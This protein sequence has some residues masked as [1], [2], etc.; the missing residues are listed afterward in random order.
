MGMRD[1]TFSALFLFLLWLLLLF[2]QPSWP[3]L[4]LGQYE[5]E[6][7]VGTWNILGVTNATSIGLGD[8]RFAFATDCSASL[9]NPALI[10]NL[11]KPTF[12]LHSSFHS[13]S[14]FK[15]SIVNTG[16]VTTDKN[17]TLKTYSIDHAAVFVRL[18]GWAF[19]L[20]QALTEIYDRPSVEQN[21]YYK[22]SLYYTLNFD[23]EGNLKT[24]HFSAARKITKR[25]SLGLGINYV[26]G[27]LK[28]NLEERWLNTNITI[29]DNK[30]HDFK[31][32]YFNGGVWARL[33]EKLAVAAIFRTPYTKKAESQSLYRYQSPQGE[34][35]IKIEASSQNK[36]KQPLVLGLGISYR[37]SPKIRI[38]S[39]LSFF[40]W[41]K[42]KVNYYE[43]ELERNFKNVV[44]VGAGIEY[45]SDL[46]IFSQNVQIP[47]RAGFIYDPQPMKVSD[48]SYLS[49]SF[50]TG[51]HWGKFLLD[52][53]AFI[54]QESGSGDSLSARKISLSL[55]FS[56]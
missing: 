30:S 25:I 56:M 24:I 37:F 5:D 32:Y 51:I 13:T 50:G 23:Q 19:T 39:D 27:H 35:D 10:P 55:S 33:S 52:I 12:S 17:L 44:K 6:A 42:Y 38:A 2:A 3:Q 43:E 49:F 26:Y 34:T 36:Y 4:I 14:F 41:S 22:D 46:R 28:K 18:K 31:G 54:G 9:S 7:P 1:K 15:Y 11:E 20:I 8:T 21:A 16:V 45:L 47:F 48:S 40:N 53:G 29:T